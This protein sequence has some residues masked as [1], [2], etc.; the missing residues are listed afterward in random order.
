VLSY[1]IVTSTVNDQTVSAR[2]TVQISAPSD[3]ADVMILIEEVAE[4]QHGLSNILK[5]LMDRIVKNFKYKKIE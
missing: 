4:D 1:N 3:V 2:S 5:L